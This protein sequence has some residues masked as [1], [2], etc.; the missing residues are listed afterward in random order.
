MEVE[1]VRGSRSWN[2]KGEVAGQ[3]GEVS[4]VGASYR[5]CVRQDAQ[6]CGLPMGPSRSIQSRNLRK[7]QMVN[8]RVGVLAGAR[9]LT[10][11]D[12]P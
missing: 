11:P 10:D 3:E 8:C 1:P 2:I 9:M 12:G 6:L 4:L 7:H 5:L